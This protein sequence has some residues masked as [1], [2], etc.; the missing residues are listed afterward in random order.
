MTHFPVTRIT[1]IPHCAQLYDT[2]GDYREIDDYSGRPVWLLRVSNMGDWRH[3]ALVVIHELVEMV[4]TKNDGVSWKDIDHFDTEGDGKDH[5]DPGTLE[6]APYHKQ[7]TF[8]TYIEREVA[9]ALGVNWDD[10][11][12][13]LNTLEYR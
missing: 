4:L 2:A 8:A 5:P 6:S 1:S 11:E 12:K 7:H 10:Y 3:E 13:E 9:L